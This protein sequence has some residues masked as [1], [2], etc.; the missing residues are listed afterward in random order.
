[1]G[2]HSWIVGFH[3]DNEDI[4]LWSTIESQNEIYNTPRNGNENLSK[5]G[6]E[7]FMLTETTS[8]T[9]CKATHSKDKRIAIPFGNNGGWAD[10]YQ[11]LMRNR[12]IPIE[13]TTT[14]RKRSNAQLPI[15]IK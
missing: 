14:I 7:S 1:M 10:I 9:I 11:F 6:Q 15:D 13:Y 2:W 12:I 4:L 3:N 5:V 8:A